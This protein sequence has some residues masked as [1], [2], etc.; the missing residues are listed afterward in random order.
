SFREE[1]I[2]FMEN[3]I[4]KFVANAV[5]NENVKALNS[6][7]EEIKAEIEEDDLKVSF[8]LSYELNDKPI[9][10]IS[11]DKLVLGTTYEKMFDLAGVNS[12]LNSLF[13]DNENTAYIAE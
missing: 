6:L 7:L 12:P 11:N 13:E 10:Y 3:T 4:Y 8:D 2:T 1:F 9:A 5:G